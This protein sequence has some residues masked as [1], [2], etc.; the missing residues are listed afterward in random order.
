MGM[1]DG[2]PVH[3]DDVA[4]PGTNIGAGLLVRA[5]LELAKYA[6][7][8]ARCALRDTSERLRPEPHRALRHVP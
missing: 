5:G 8:T 2:L 4:N 1:S 7:C 6:C 3:A